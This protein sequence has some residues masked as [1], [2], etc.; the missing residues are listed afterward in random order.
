MQF[1]RRAAPQRDLNHPQGL[2]DLPALCERLAP[3]GLFDAYLVAAQSEGSAREQQCPCEVPQGKDRKAVT[4]LACCVCPLAHY[5][6][7]SI[8]PI[9][10]TLALRER[11]KV[12]R[13][14]GD[15]C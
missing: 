2:A 9:S 1:S 12:L 11:D 15:R 14:L 7:R 3:N 5:Y 8:L 6:R 10:C 4:A 13:S